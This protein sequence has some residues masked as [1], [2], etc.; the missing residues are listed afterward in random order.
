M[1]DFGVGEQDRMASSS[2]WAHR[3][4]EH[5]ILI[6]FAFFLTDSVLR[7]FGRMYHLL[8]S[9][10]IHE[11]MH[12]C[13]CKSWTS[14]NKQNLLME[15]VRSRSIKGRKLNYSCYRMRNAT[16]VLWRTTFS[17]GLL[18]WLT[19]SYKKQQFVNHVVIFKKMK[20]KWIVQSVTE[21]LAFA[22]W[23]QWLT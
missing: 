2:P 14:F 9:H 13:A 17:P 12:V 5:Y 11:S 6:I 22:F 23:K 18:T 8:I 4:I 3:Q 7:V 19:A 20:K 16:Y 15:L 1:Q 10:S 21:I